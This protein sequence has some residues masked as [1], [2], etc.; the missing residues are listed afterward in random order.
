V[1]ETTSAATSNPLTWTVPFDET[2][3]D[4]ATTSRTSLESDRGWRVLATLSFVALG[5]WILFSVIGITLIA[6]SQHRRRK[7]R[8]SLAK[9]MELEARDDY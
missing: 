2:L 7:R 5:V 4:V 1:Q 8:R 6:R 3:V 9:L